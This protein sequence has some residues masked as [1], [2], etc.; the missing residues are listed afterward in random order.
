MDIQCGTRPRGVTLGH[1]LGAL[2]VG[3]HLRNGFRNSTNG[4]GSAQNCHRTAERRVGLTRSGRESCDQRLEPRL[5]V[6]E[7]R[8]SITDEQRIKVEIEEPAH[9]LP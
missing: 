3:A 1:V 6:F 5:G 9:A 2:V 8:L 4:A 7:D